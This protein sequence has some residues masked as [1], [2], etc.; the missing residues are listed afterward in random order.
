L[1]S[2]LC[3]AR[4]KC[5]T[6]RSAMARSRYLSISR[7]AFLRSR[8]LEEICFRY[9]DFLSRFQRNPYRRKVE[10]FRRFRE[11]SAFRPLEG[12]ESDR[13][14]H[15]R[16]WNRT[17]LL[18]AHSIFLMKKRIYFTLSSFIHSRTSPTGPCPS[19]LNARPHL[20][21]SLPSFLLGAPSFY[22]F[23][24]SSC[25]DIDFPLGSRLPR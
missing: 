6:T 12:R 15:P 25:P 5:G 16:S 1:D 20:E 3:V 21:F 23:A 9:A 18:M 22:L 4:D 7:R 10:R 19:S 13:P 11:F 24:R 17:P 8:E 2:Q 14:L